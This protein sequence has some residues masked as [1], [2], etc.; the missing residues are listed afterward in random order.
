M[1]RDKF[2]RRYL[3]GRHESPCKAFYSTFVYDVIDPDHFFGKGIYCVLRSGSMNGRAKG[4]HRDNR[5]GDQGQGIILA[6][7][8]RYPLK[9]I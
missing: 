1:V 9:K 2:I 5:K 7:S 4:D 8:V 3:V 6:F